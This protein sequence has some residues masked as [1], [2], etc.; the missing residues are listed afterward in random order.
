MWWVSIVLIVA[1]APSME[2]WWPTWWLPS[3]SGSFALSS[4]GPALFGRKV[5]EARSWG[6]VSLS[7][8]VEAVLRVVLD[9]HVQSYTCWQRRRNRSNKHLK[10]GTTHWL[11]C[12]WNCDRQMH[13]CVS[14]SRRDK[15]GLVLCHQSMLQLHPDVESTRNSID[16]WTRPTSRSITHTQHTQICTAQSVAFQKKTSPHILRRNAQKSQSKVLWLTGLQSPKTLS[17]QTGGLLP[18]WTHVYGTI[19]WYDISSWRWKYYGHMLQCSFNS[20]DRIRQQETSKLDLKTFLCR[21][22]QPCLFSKPCAF[23]RR[24][25]CFLGLVLLRSFF[26]CKTLVHHLLNTKLSTR[27][28]MHFSGRVCTHRLE[29]WAF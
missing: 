2:C 28:Y 12:S 16:W 19:S 15:S 9:P 4:T 13:K 17:K 21:F 1:P 24:S 7:T 27:V 23:R 18:I 11:A 29:S 5:W 3:Q 26:H 8:F 20:S 22:Q 10:H 25:L 14:G 6:C